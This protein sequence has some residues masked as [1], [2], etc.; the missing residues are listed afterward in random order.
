M[1]AI[2][3]SNF[4]FAD[5]GHISLEWV[6]YNSRDDPKCYMVIFKR[7]RR[8]IWRDIRTCIFPLGDYE[9]IITIILGVLQDCLVTLQVGVG[10]CIW[11]GLSNKL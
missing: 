11:A 7:E 4:S 2:Q 1:N 8:D 9:R 3:I 5:K 6:T 10:L